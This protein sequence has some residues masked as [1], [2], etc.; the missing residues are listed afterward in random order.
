MI[1]R[2][3][4][5]PSFNP[6]KDNSSIWVWDNVVQTLYTNGT[7]D[8]GPQPQL[9]TS[10]DVSADK[11]SWT[12]HLRPGV[13]FQNGQPL[14]S[15]DVKFSLDRARRPDGPWSFIDG[16][17]ADVSA[18]D[19]NTVVI[20][21]KY[22]W[23]PLLA[24][25]ALFDNGVIPANFAGQ[26]E[27]DFFEH[28]IGTG[29]FQ[30]DK[31]IKGT[32][33]RLVRNPSYWEAGKPYLDAV[34]WQVVSDDNT[35]LLQLKG[36]QVQVDEFPPFSSLDSLKTTP[37]VA[38]D[39]FPGTGMDYVTPNFAVKALNDVHLRRAMALA[40]D[41]DAIVKAT[42]F[43][44]AKPA[45]SLFMPTLPFYTSTEAGTLD[46][47]KA[48]AELAQSSTPTGTSLEFLYASGSAQQT[49]I[50]QL[51]QSDLAKIGVTLKLKG[52][53]QNALYDLW[54]KGKYELAVVNWT[55]D[56]L[57]ADEW[58]SFAVDPGAGSNAAFTGYKNQQVIDLVHQAQ[59]TLDP[60]A[61]GQ[62]YAQLQQMTSADAFMFYL[63]YSPFQ[64]ARSSKVNGF[65]VLPT[66][67]YHLEDVWLS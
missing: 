34:T 5:S 43:G 48:K 38:V 57:D 2:A 46:L 27:K 7:G 6:L 66:G 62:I 11:L 56:I 1:A 12:F 31:W 21:T 64:Y 19:A 30:W 3:S 55:M 45:D 32:S 28:P 13:K 24:D 26:T 35:R 8:Q 37:G 40:I 63:D 29:P 18:K 36:G 42:F 59:R 49:T 4:D 50:A 60:A 16:A 20:K 65:K 39:L 67:N 14:T 58:V 53:E 33:L 54:A 17:I 9:A 51:L 41:R 22:P 52:V 23:A 44:N 10:Y 61:R 15:A 25:L 47:A